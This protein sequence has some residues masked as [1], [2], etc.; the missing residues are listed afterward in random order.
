[1]FRYFL[2]VWRA[3]RQ[4]YFIGRVDWTEADAG[5]W[6]NFL[7]TPTG[8]KLKAHLRNSSISRAFW[9]SS[10]ERGDAWASGVA[11]GQ[12]LNIAEIESLSV[13]RPTSGSSGSPDAEN[14]GNTEQWDGTPKGLDN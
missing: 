6:L 7:S 8:K 12:R 3:S 9:A 10:K 4:P 1:M 11:F 2:A 5:A 13:A 14:L